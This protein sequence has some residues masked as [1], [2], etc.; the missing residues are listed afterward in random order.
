MDGVREWI[1][2]YVRLVEECLRFVDLLED[3]F[4]SAVVSLHDGVLGGHELAH[5]CEFGGYAVK[6]DATYEVHLLGE[7]HLE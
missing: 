5:R 6:L 4:E 3:V 2:I 7:G 1:Y